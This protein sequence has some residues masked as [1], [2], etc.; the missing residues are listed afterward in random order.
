[1]QSVTRGLGKEGGR[2]TIWDL[3]SGKRADCGVDIDGVYD[4]LIRPAVHFLP[5]DRYVV[6]LWNGSVDVLDTRT[7]T[8]SAVLP[9]PEDGSLSLALSGDRGTLVVLD[10]SG[11]DVD[12]WRWDGDRAFEHAAHT[13]LPQEAEPIGISVD[14][15]GNQ[16]AFSDLES[17]AYV[18][19]LDSGQ[20]VRATGNLPRDT[21]DVALSR[22]GS[23]L[24][25][26]FSTRTDRG[27]RILDAA[28]GDQLDVWHTDPPA[29]SAK[30]EAPMQVVPGPAD[31]ILTLGPDRKVV[32]RTVG[33]E[34]WRD[35]L[36][37][38]VSQPLPARERDRYLKGLNVEA[39]CR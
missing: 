34:A 16:A 23:L 14:H 27:V 31:D 32:R 4:D 19:R 25:Q 8:R 21:H 29:A 28:T 6:G 9:E 38:L 18:V 37:G 24:I 1:M 22:D 20:R 39:P 17:H 36:C 13:T 7:C 33:V 15:E 3:R 26:G 11:N 10:R 35:L 12:T 5:G 2:F 30:P